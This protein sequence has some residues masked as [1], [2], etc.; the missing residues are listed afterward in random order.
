MF[1]HDKMFILIT[2]KE[3]FVQFVVLVDRERK[4]VQTKVNVMDMEDVV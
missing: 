2:W 3:Y 4:Q 1:V